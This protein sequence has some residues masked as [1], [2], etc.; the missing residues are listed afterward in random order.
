MALPPLFIHLKVLL[1]GHPATS[2]SPALTP[3]VRLAACFP[4][5]PSLRTMATVLAR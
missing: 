5:F 3:Q 1:F 2:F 4:G